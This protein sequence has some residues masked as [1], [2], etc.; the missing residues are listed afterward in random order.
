MDLNFIDDIEITDQNAEAAG[1][2][3]SGIAAMAG[4]GTIVVPLIGLGVQLGLKLCNGGYEA[5]GLSFLQEIAKE[6]EELPDL[7]V[8]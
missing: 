4:A 2:V 8:E 1:V 7:T 6:L 5:R 3:V